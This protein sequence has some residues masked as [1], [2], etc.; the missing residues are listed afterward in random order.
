M[1]FGEK[2]NIRPASP[3][4]IERIEG[5]LLSYGNERRCENNPLEVGFEKYFTLDGSIEFIG[6]SA[7]QQIYKRGIGRQIRGVTFGTDSSPIFSDP[8]PVFCG[9][10]AVGQIT[11][12][13]WSPRLKTNVGLSLINRDFWNISQKVLVDTLD[14]RMR[15]G[16]LVNLPM[17]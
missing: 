2:Y 7:L 5:E 15:L 10:I 12:G 17:L 13:I 1:E 6:L 16:K 9:D 14:K 3:N 8:W 4:F 11:S